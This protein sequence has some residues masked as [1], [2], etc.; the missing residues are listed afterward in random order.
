MSQCSKHMNVWLRQAFPKGHLQGQQASALNDPQNPIQHVQGPSISLDTA[1]SSSLVTAHLA[2]GCLHHGGCARGLSV[3]V[4]LP[5][6][7]ETSFMFVGAGMTAAD[8]R[9]KTLDASAD[10]YVRS[11]ACMAMLFRY[12][13]LP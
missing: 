3:G 10:G 12:Q 4:N 1:C 9:C 5:M 11:E 8:G 6:N 2:A 7:W 13:M